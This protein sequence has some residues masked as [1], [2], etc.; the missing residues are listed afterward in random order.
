MAEPQTKS[1][2]LKTRILA[3]AGGFLAAA[4]SLGWSIY[5][6]RNQEKAPLVSAGTVVDAGRWKVTLASSRIDITTPDGLKLLE[7]KKALVVDLTLENITAESSNIYYETLRLDNVPD[8]PTPQ[9]F[10]VR[11]K[12]VLGD[13]QPLMPEAVAAVWQLPSNAVLPK[14]LD[15]SIIGSKFKPKDNLYA[16]PGWFNPKDVAKVELPIAGGGH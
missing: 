8:A 2:K 13:L 9:F 3:G 11:D 12:D 10:L 14:T 1:A 15:V 4:L 6:V 16:A 5:D 7:G